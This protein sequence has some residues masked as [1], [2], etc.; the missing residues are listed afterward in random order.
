MNLSLK[1]KELLQSH[2]SLKKPLIKL[3]TAIKYNILKNHFMHLRTLKPNYME[4]G[5]FYKHLQYKDDYEIGSNSLR[6]N[7]VVKQFKY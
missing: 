7:V 5:H 1:R 2:I 3:I 6:K 4:N